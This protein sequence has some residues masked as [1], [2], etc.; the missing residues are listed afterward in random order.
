MRREVGSIEEGNSE[1]HIFDHPVLMTTKGPISTML[2]LALSAVL[3]S[4]PTKGPAFAFSSTL[5]DFAVLQEQPAAAAVYGVTGKSTVGESN[6]NVEIRLV[7]DEIDSR[8]ST[9]ANISADGTQWKALLHPHPTGGNISVTATCTGCSSEEEVAVLKGLTYG[10]VRRTPKVVCL[11]V[12]HTL[13]LPIPCTALGDRST[14]Q[15]YVNLLRTQQDC[16]NFADV[17]SVNDVMHYRSGKSF[18]SK[19][20]SLL[21]RYAACLPA[22]FHSNTTHTHTSDVQ[23]HTHTF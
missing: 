8:Y 22:T 13:P 18:S 1:S 2:V 19:W 15:I 23:H 3:A 7:I 5:S 9:V 4:K 20:T 10:D 16:F 21:K 14:R 17:R 12:I 6:I 11:T